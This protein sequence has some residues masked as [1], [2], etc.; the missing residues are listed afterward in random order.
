M[1]H[2]F[3]CTSSSLLLQPTATFITPPMHYSVYACEV[4]SGEDALHA[5][6]IA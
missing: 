3:V 5:S 4:A 6:G 1:L 2:F